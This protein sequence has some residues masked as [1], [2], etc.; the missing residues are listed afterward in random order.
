MLNIS[1]LSVF[2][3]NFINWVKVCFFEFFYK[4]YLNCVF[5]FLRY[6]LGDY[7]EILGEWVGLMGLVGEDGEG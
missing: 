5:I 7:G 3:V 6:I 1:P 4:K 2:S